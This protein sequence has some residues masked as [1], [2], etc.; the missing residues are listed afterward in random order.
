MPCT[1]MAKAK[2][3]AVVGVPESSNDRVSADGVI[4]IPGGRVP[5]DTVQMNGTPPDLVL[6]VAEYAVP[7]VPFGK[8]VVVIFT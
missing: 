2:L 8:D 4:P 3:P 5:A 1:V 7:T 6:T